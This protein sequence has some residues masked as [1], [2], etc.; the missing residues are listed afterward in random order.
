MPSEAVIFLFA[1]KPT[2]VSVFDEKNQTISSHDTK[3][4]VA[5]TLANSNAS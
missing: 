1:L 3:D 5:L 2:I 4:P